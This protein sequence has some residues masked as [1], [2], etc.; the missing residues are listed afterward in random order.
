MLY[1][2]PHRLSGL[3][4]PPT[5]LLQFKWGFESKFA[6]PWSPFYH[7]HTERSIESLIT[8]AKSSAQIRLGDFAYA[9][10]YERTEI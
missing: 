4:T 3:V 1:Y 8:V 10:T 7:E 6:S 9:L 5:S 2:E